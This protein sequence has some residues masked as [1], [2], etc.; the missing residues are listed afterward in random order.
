MLRPLTTFLGDFVWVGVAQGWI[1][2]RDHIK[3]RGVVVCSCMCSV[4]LQDRL[5][6]SLTSF[7][8]EGY[9][10]FWDPVYIGRYFTLSL[11]EFLSLSFSAP[12]LCRLNLV[13]ST[14]GQFS[15]LCKSLYAFPRGKRDVGFL[16]CCYYQYL[17]WCKIS[18][19]TIKC[20][21]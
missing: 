17:N 4:C 8:G 11:F 10:A 12:Q 1:W 21:C 15:L 20:L 3:G 5:L 13:S 7:Y 19:N 9:P 18:G 2:S 6:E 16:G 14:K